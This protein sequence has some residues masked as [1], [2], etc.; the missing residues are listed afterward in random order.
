MKQDLLCTKQ[1]SRAEEEKGGR[2]RER[3]QM[4]RVK[5]WEE[6]LRARRKRKNMW[7]GGR[8]GLRGREMN[9]FSVLASVFNMIVYEWFCVSLC[10]CLS[11]CV[12]VFVCVC[13]C[14]CEVILF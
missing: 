11:V 5:E 10:M 4:E 14:V 3:G 7:W 2:E 8:E 12:C 1:Q 13:V 6:E 9:V